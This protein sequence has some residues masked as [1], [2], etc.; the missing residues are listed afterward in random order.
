MD[1]AI[2]AGK[3]TAPDMMRDHYITR[4]MADPDAVEAEIGAM[5]SLCRPGPAT[6][7][8]PQLQAGPAGLDGDEAKIVSLMSL[9]PELYAKVKAA[10]AEREE[11]LAFPDRKG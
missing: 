2:R 6:A 5:V 10:Q 3:V 8:P 4:H 1:G 7:R 9:D 11:T